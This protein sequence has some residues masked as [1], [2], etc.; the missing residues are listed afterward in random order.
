MRILRLLAAGRDL[1]VRAVRFSA[2]EPANR[3]RYEEVM[4]CRDLTFGDSVDAIA[5]G[6]DSLRQ[7]IPRPS[8]TVSAFLREL[9]DSQ[10]ASVKNSGLTGMKV[11]DIIAR[12]RGGNPPDLRSAAAALRMSTRTLQR[13]LQH[14]GTSFSAIADDVQRDKAHRLLR[15]STKSLKE[16]AFELG[17]REVR[18]F[19]RASLRWFGQ[20][21][22]DY[23]QGHRSG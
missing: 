9:A 5:F 12:G 2:P 17:F 11:R 23:R 21:A 1:E 8:G 15:H 20:T 18:S 13:N 7:P 14:E 19:M 6:L 22:S 16:I 10:L 3:S 4:L